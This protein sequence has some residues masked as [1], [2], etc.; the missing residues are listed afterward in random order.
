MKS[1]QLDIQEME[2]KFVV[3]IDKN[4]LSP[5]YILNLVNWLQYVSIG[6]NEL[7]NYF[8]KFQQMPIKQATSIE[9]KKRTWNYSGSVNLNNKLDNINLRDFAHE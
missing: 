9:P 2:N 7:N 4:Q 3:T 6:Q 8:I 5:D 1:Y